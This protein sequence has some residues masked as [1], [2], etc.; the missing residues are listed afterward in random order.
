[1]KINSIN[2]GYEYYQVEET[3]IEVRKKDYRITEIDECDK[4]DGKLGTKFHGFALYCCKTVV[5]FVPYDA[6]TLITY[7]VE[8]VD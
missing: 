7:E 5:G 6:V 8:N 2:C 3:T 1:M 4:V